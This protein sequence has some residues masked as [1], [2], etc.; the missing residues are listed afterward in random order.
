[1]TEMVPYQKKL[2]DLRGALLRS[3]SEI[4]KALPAHLDADRMFRLYLTCAQVTP[5]LADCEQISVIGAV[6]QAA[7]LGLSLETVLGEAYLIPRRNKNMGG[8]YVAHFQIGYK[9][10]RKLAKVGDLQIRDIYAIPVFKNDIFDYEYGDEP[11]VTHK[12]ARANRGEIV[13]AYARAIWT[14]GYKRSWVIG[15]EDVERAQKSSDSFQRAARDGNDGSPWMT[16]PEAM[17]MKTALLRL[18]R[19]LPLASESP[20]A[21][22]MAAEH[23]DGRALLTQL[24]DSPDVLVMPPSNGASEREPAPAKSAL[25]QVV[26]QARQQPPAEGP[27]RRRRTEPEPQPPPDAEPEPAESEP[28]TREPGEDG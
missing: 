25:D 22:A 6:M 23:V 20:L 9:G 5:R 16:D 13:N 18:C 14:D 27:K 4:L 15:P 3:K 26:A 11:K 10:L 24:H 2:A 19:Q 12:P 8:A 28:A 1:M 7:Q 17:W 21:R